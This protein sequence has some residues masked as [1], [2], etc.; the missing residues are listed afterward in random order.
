MLR[1]QDLMFFQIKKEIEKNKNIGKT[2]EE[3][4]IE[5]FKNNDT[6]FIFDEVDYL[7]DPL[8]WN[9]NVEKEK[10]MFDYEKFKIIYEKIYNFLFEWLVYDEDEKEETQEYKLIKINDND[11]NVILQYKQY[12]ELK[13]IEIFL[14]KNNN[15]EFE[16]I[17][18]EKI[19]EIV[20]TSI[21]N[22]WY[23]LDISKDFFMNSKKKIAIP[24][25]ADY[26]PLKGSKFLNYYMTYMFTITSHILLN[27]TNII[28]ECD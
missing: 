20:L 19:F 23:G 1:T 27:Y 21:Y 13:K 24:F 9:C 26:K 8:K 11:G 4:I 7:Y 6:L 10:K 3:K 5:I 17:K 12:K 2:N 16:N 15:D 28:N 18:N 14:K 22:K 25:E